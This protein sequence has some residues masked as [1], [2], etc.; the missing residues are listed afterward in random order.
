MAVPGYH[1]ALS[2]AFFF[3]EARRVRCESAHS[4]IEKK[5]VPSSFSMTDKHLK[6]DQIYSDMYLLKYI[7]E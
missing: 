3:L 6:M 1:R 7:N 5:K 2:C 4:M